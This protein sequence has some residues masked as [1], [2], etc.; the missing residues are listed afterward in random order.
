MR[1][2]VASLTPSD[3]AINS[4]SISIVA[5]CVKCGSSYK[6]LK[7]CREMIDFDLFKEREKERKK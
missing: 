3:I 4:F 2:V 1:M 7:M 5:W 6:C